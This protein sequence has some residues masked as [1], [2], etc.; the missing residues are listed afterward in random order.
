MPLHDW[1]RVLAGTFHDFHYC[2]VAE[3]RHALNRGL[4]PEGYDAQA[5]QVAGAKIPDV[6]TLQAV[7]E[8]GISPSPSALENGAVAISE[9]PPQVSLT[10]EAEESWYA[11]KRDRIAVRHRSGDQTVA[12]IDVVSPGNKRSTAE[13]MRFFA[14]VDSALHSGVHVLVL[15]LH[16]AGRHDP[17][18]I[19]AAFWEYAFG[20][21]SSI[22]DP[23]RGTLVSY[24]AHPSMIA[25][26]YVQPVSLGEPMPAM[27]LFL[28]PAWYINV[29][30]EETYMK[31]FAEF[32]DRW[33]R[34]LDGHGQ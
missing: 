1:S 8:T 13:L 23:P 33:R 17:R 24:R 16:P 9:H 15:D 31:A 5:E 27:P 29:P 19:H 25:T 18:G 22:V 30:I 3:L 11:R 7:D 26:A 20:P 12:L 6:R 10:E 14:K 32:P 34:V 21:E 4:L 2:W 28:D